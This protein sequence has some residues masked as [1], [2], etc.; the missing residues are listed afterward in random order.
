MCSDLFHREKIRSRLN[1]YIN[2]FEVDIMT[3]E[4]I[5]LEAFRQI[6][7][8]ISNFEDNSSNDEIAGYVKGVVD[9]ESELYS[10]LLRESTR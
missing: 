5:E 4:Q 7:Q 9:L 10:M 3:I 2:G 6:R 8:K 1:S